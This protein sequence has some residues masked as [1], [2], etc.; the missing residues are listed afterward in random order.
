MK[1]IFLTLS[2]ALVTTLMIA[3]TKPNATG[4]NTTAP[5]K[6]A[7]SVKTTTPSTVAPAPTTAPVTTSTGKFKWSEDTWDFGSIPQGIP[8]THS[9]EF[10]NVGTE[11]IVIS[12]CQKSCGCTTPKWTTEPVLPGKKGFVSATF[13]AASPNAFTKTVTVHSNAEGGDKV[14]YIK[15]TVVAKPTENTNEVAPAPTTNPHN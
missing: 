1:K 8:V 12:D 5:Q 14:L 10:T 15:G 2:L 9:F 11:P 7:P 6:V 13:N 3:Q 4:A